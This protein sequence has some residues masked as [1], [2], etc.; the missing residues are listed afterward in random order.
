M[1]DSPTL[2]GE[3]GSGPHAPLTLMTRMLRL[4]VPATAALGAAVV[5]IAEGG[6]WPFPA[7]LFGMALC[8]CA[9][10]ALAA[11]IRS[12]TLAFWGLVALHMAA[13]LLAVYIWRD[14]VLL[15]FVLIPFALIAGV[16]GWRAV[17]VG[18]PVLLAAGW[19]L[20]RYELVSWS[21]IGVLT[22]TAGAVALALHESVV[23]SEEAATW[24]WHYC[25]EA[26]KQLQD[27]RDQRLRLKQAEADLLLAHTELQRVNERLA[28]MRELA[29][30]ARRAK[31]QFLA[32]VSH[33]LRTPLNMI[34]FL[35]R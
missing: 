29:D 21:T 20:A 11:T 30:D 28:A 18:V 1:L 27:A 9:V 12:T 32:N 22:V 10:L 33:E 24:A 23:D 2:R 14:E 13:S 16:Y 19:C 15:F 4:C 25:E 35:L 34:I 6:Q 17:A 31:E 7:S 3:Y 8:V 5:L 26:R